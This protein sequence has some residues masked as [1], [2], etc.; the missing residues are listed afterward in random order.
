M[1]T[2]LPFVITIDQMTKINEMQNWQKA[3]KRNFIL[4]LT[5]ATANKIQWNWN[6]S[7]CFILWNFVISHEILLDFVKLCNFLFALVKVQKIYAKNI[8]K[9]T[10][11]IHQIQAEFCKLSFMQWKRMK[12]DQILSKTVTKFHC[13]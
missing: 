10:W 11:K 4:S 1:L 12:V 2:I 3:N 5:E 8:A 9:M 13:I 7:A 6:I